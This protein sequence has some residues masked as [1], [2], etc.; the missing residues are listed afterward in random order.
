MSKTLV[1]VESPTK[2]RTITRFLGG[3]TKVLASMGHIRDLP[4]RSLGIDLQHGFAPAYEL[5]A[6][7]KR[8]IADLLKEAR[9]ATDVYLAPDPDREGEA[10]AWHLA[11]LLRPKSKAHFHRVTFHEITR[12]AIQHAFEQPG[13][14]D[15]HKVDAQQAR[16]V[17]DRIVGYQVSPLLWQQVQKGTSAGRVQSVALRLI[18]ERQ[19]EIDGFTPVEYWTLDA[20]FSAHQPAASFGARLAQLDGRKLPFDGKAALIPD[21]A[22]ANA[23]AAELERPDTRYRVAKV[24]STPKFQRAAPPFITSTLQQAAGTNLGMGSGRTMRLA[25]DLY[26]GVDTGDGPVGLITYMR[27]DSFEVAREA[28]AAARDFIGQAFGAEFIP[29]KPNFYRSRASAQG[30]HEAI[31][32]TDVSRTPESLAPYLNPDQLRLYRLIWN[33]FLASQMAP[34][35]LV[36]DSIEVEAEGAG[37]THRYLFRTS[38]SRVVFPGFRKL[39]DFK[40]TES[41]KPGEEE[42]EGAPRNRNLPALPEGTACAL[43]ALAKAQKSTEPPRQF[44]EAM[45]VKELEQNGIGRPST[46]ASIVET[47]QEREYVTKDKGR[48]TPTTLGY[49]VNDFLV[50]RLPQLFQVGFTADME[51]KLD[52]I[53]EGKVG[54]QEMLAEFY[55]R[56][57]EWGGAD[58]GAN[59][60]ANPEVLRFLQAFPP[61]LAWRPAEKRGRRT[62]DDKAFHDSLLEQATSGKPFSDKQW[63]ATLALAAHYAEQ[64][65]GILEAAREL[66]AADQLDALVR[67]QAEPREERAAAHPA[68]SVEPLV[69]AMARIDWEAPVKR[70]K[71]TYDDKKFFKSLARQVA[72]GVGLSEPQMAALRK[73]A[74][75]YQAQLP[76]FAE[77]AARFQIGAGTAATTEGAETAEPAADTAKLEGLMAMLADVKQWAEP[78]QRRGW[79]F[80][81]RKFAE[82]L[83]EQ[84]RKRKSLSPK[85]A[86]AI[87]KLLR[88][89][90]E[91]IPDFAGRCATLGLDAEPPQPPTVA[92]NCPQCGAPLLQR[93]YRGRTFFGCSAYPRCKFAVN[94][95][96]KLPPPPT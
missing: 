90:R 35:K 72:D 76:E 8:V 40:E 70:G 64:A 93:A 17:L 67:K 83:Q 44:T 21:A 62:Y 41:A 22:A 92:A 77:L 54:W 60:P 59:A 11:E 27:T 81:D 91:Q 56:F 65:P 94:S 79:T 33:R 50:A 18:C 7:G 20:S 25:Q 9:S 15:Q 74:L 6:N 52:E 88:K 28:Q 4:Q 84:F 46:Y 96:D 89:Y 61:S 42:E 39:Y 47:I 3:G 29:E 53:E 48:L 66:K 34:A 58:A 2:A 57:R 10:I 82:S 19:R 30:A 14:I 23:L 68:A 75:K 36:E 55:Q 51:T 37:L 31:R 71:R 73:L 95:L 80:D 45:L 49:A 38:A 16:R 63:Q 26:E 12:S 43:D 87:T 69:A 24:A 13:Q 78:T 1:I 5:T 85:Q 86:E 32:P